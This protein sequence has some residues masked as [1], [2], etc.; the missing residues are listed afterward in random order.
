MLDFAG[1]AKWDEWNK[2]KGMS[3]QDAEKLYIDKVKQ[4]IEQYGLK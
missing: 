4:L 3:K 2:H 1:K